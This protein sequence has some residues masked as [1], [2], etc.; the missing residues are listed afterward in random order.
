MM[1]SSVAELRPLIPEIIVLAGGL[2]LMMFEAFSG[3]K[4][5]R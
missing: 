2:F 4:Q 3:P 1:M 5:R